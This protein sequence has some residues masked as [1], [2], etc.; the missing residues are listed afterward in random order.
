MIG[1]TSVEESSEEVLYPSISV[2]SIRE[3]LLL[4]LT[5]QNVSSFHRSLNLSEWILSIEM[6]KKNDSGSLEKI[7][8]GPKHGNIEDRDNNCHQFI[9]HTSSPPHSEN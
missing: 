4:N 2:C 3:R 9:L 1:T 8:L 5:Q 6:W 7:I